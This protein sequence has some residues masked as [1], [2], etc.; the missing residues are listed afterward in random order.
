[1][2]SNRLILD[3]DFKSSASFLILILNQLVLIILILILKIILLMILNHNKS[4]SKEPLQ[5][6]APCSMA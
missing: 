6:T 1:M 5:D 4:L 3:R 2:I